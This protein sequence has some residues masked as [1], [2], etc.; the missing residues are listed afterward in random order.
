MINKKQR[1]EMII[2]LKSLRNINTLIVTNV[3]MVL[4]LMSFSFVYHMWVLV[5]FLFIQ[6]VFPL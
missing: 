6:N 5:I 1:C 3:L 2:L 4:I